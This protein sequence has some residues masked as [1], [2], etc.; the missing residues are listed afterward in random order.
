MR[1]SSK[2]DF[3]DEFNDDDNDDD[4]E[5]EEEARRVGHV[6]ERGTIPS[7]RMTRN[8]YAPLEWDP[9]TTYV[10]TPL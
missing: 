3:D 7:P 10:Y 2:D 4:E 1:Y 6:F 8:S 5:E 9:S